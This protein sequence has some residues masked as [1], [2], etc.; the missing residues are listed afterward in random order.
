MIFYSDN[1]RYNK[2]NLAIYL[3]SEIS[4]KENGARS[5]KIIYLINY[6]Y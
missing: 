1:P 4:N 5:N 6:I 2:E 3:K